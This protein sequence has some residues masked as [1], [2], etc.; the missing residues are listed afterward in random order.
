MWCGDRG[1]EMEKDEGGSDQSNKQAGI[2]GKK[3]K[4]LMEN[5]SSQSLS[6]TQ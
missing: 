1:M 6:L 5:L 4:Y 2:N 3:E